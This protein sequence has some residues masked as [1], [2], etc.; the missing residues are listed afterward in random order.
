MTGRCASFY[1]YE[2]VIGIGRNIFL[3]AIR[4][5]TVTVALNIELAFIRKYFLY[6]WLRVA[7]SA[8][9]TAKCKS[10]VERGR[11]KA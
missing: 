3:L 11:D 1:M 7:A 2:T 9:A 6:G 8:T 5:T 4:R 10:P